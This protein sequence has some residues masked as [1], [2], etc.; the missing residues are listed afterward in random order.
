M[1]PEKSDVL[2]GTLA[3]MVLKTLDVMGPLHGYALA[4]RI[5]QISGDQLALNQGT[6][7]PALLKLQQ[8]GWIAGTWGDS[9]TGRR[10]RFYAITPAGRKQLQAEAENWLRAS[11]IVARFVKGLP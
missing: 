3:L 10:A 4:R 9:E 6:L 11:S 1:V 5:E 7:Y 2:Y 8:M